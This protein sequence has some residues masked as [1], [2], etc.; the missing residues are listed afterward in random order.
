MTIQ[1]SQHIYVLLKNC[2][3]HIANQNMRTYVLRNSNR[4]TSSSFGWNMEQ[5]NTMPCLYLRCVSDST[6]GFFP[7]N[8]TWWGWRYQTFKF[9]QYSEV[10]I[11]CDAYVCDKQ[12]TVPQCDR[13]CFP[14]TTVQ[15]AGPSKL[16]QYI[17][18]NTRAV[19]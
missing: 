6:V 13:S 2:R 5:T 18:G 16:F 3:Y 8:E 10:H 14:T 19:Q 15:P 7:M 9:V 4:N 11:H 12:D 17:I 1:S